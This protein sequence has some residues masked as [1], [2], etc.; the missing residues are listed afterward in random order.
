MEQKRDPGIKWGGLFFFKLPC[1]CACVLILPF[2]SLFIQLLLYVHSLRGLWFFVTPE[3]AARQTSLHCL[4]EFA[5]THVHWVDNTIQQSY[6]LLPPFSSCPQSLPASE[7]F[8]E[9]ARPIRWPKY[10]SFSFSIS[11][12]NEYS[13]LIFSRIDWFDLFA[14]QGTLKSLLQHHTSKVSFLRHSA[15]FTAQLS[16]N[17]YWKNHSFDYTDLCQQGDVSAF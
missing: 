13:G 10:W 11:P 9:S 1:V 14:V 4:R 8:S 3:A 15:F 7:S 16:V 2:I 12:S 5:Q 6:P 17:N